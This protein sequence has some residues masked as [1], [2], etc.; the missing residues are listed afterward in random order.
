M[1][2]EVVNNDPNQSP[3]RQWTQCNYPRTYGSSD[4]WL[5]GQ[6]TQ[7]WCEPTPKYVPQKWADEGGECMCKGNI[8]YT[9]GKYDGKMLNFTEAISL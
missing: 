5:A 8:Y 4:P 1:V 2:N 7:C 9:A 3:W 6:E